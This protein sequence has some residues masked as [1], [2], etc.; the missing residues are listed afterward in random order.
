MNPLLFFVAIVSLFVFVAE[1]VSMY[2][3]SR[4]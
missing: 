4:Y 2:V 1:T 3:E